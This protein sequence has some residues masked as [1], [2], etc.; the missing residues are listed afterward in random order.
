MP[1]SSIAKLLGVGVATFKGWTEKHKLLRYALRRARGTDKKSGIRTLSSH[2]VGKLPRDL[3]ELWDLAVQC[4]ELRDEG[5]S[6]GNAFYRLE[7]ML[8][9]RGLRGRQML[10]LHALVSSGFNVSSACR[11]VEIHRST[12]MNWMKNDPKF[13]ELVSEVMSAR[14]D[15]FE[16]ALF[17]RVQA[18]DTSAV[19]FA[20]KTKNRKRGYGEVLEHSH[21]GA[22]EHN[23]GMVDFTKLNLPMDVR[24]QIMEAIREQRKMELADN[25]EEMNMIARNSNENVPVRR[26]LE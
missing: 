6:E 3:R 7:K 14:D 13:G 23:H 11:M 1:N 24:K 9:D 15:F 16:E 2:L 18:G 8:E 26:S 20:N 19:I 10:C 4:E 21:S 25:S 12:F 5:V 17:R 22:V